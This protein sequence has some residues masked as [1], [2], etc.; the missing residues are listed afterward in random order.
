MKYCNSCGATI[1]DRARKCSKCGVKFNKKAEY[2]V[3]D[4]DDFSTHQI[5]PSKQKALTEKPQ[6]F[7]IPFKISKGVVMVL[8]VIPPGLG[9]IYA[10]NRKKGL[11][12]LIVF[13]IV[14]TFDV[15]TKVAFQLYAIAIPF[16]YYW[17][18]HNNYL[19]YSG[20]KQSFQEL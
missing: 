9:L 7:H 18:P 19:E 14:V 8:S 12:I 20:Y 1:K 16:H 2:D 13:L 10:G 4:Y 6:D 11:K 17:L 3:V 15:V 5:N